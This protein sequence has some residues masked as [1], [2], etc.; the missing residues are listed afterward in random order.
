[1][2]VGVWVGVCVWVQDTGDMKKVIETEW[3]SGGGGDDGGICPAT[4][5]KGRPA[6]RRSGQSGRKRRGGKE[7]QSNN[8]TQTHRRS[9]TSGQRGSK[10]CRGGNENQSNDTTRP[11]RRL[12]RRCARV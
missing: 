2:G 9:G 11:L 8:A 12:K 1:M 7:N 3:P 5:L 6:T 10:R 4:P